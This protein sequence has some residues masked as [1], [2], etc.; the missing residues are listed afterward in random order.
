MRKLILSGTALAAAALVVVSLVQPERRASAQSAALERTLL[1]L[2]PA[3]TNTLVGVDVEGVKRAPLYRYIEEHSGR[4]LDELAA[5]TG[6]DP[7]RDV[8]ELLIATWAGQPGVVRRGD[9]QF[10][11]VGRGRFDA[12]SLGREFR[13]K[14]AT[15]ENYRGLEVFALDGERKRPADRGVLV[16]LDERTALAGA[17]AAVLRA[18]D[19]KLGGGPSLLDNTDLISRARSVSGSGQIWAVSQAPGEMASIAGQQQAGPSS[20]L[21]R[22]FSSMQSSTVA[23]DLTDGVALRAAGACRTAQDAKTLA[24]AARGFVALGRLAASQKEPEVLSILDSVM[25]EERGAELDISVRVGRQ[26]MEKL[27]EQ[28]RARKPVRA[29]GLDRSR[30]NDVL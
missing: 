5:R 1:A 6:F 17:R 15:V 29:V 13:E 7:R 18:I 4:E 14:K 20:N 3:E 8:E 21:G 30:E 19:R 9:S 12:A 16:F 23:V 24:D 11:A 27:L 26:V 2:L 22:I 25:V 10:L 28:D